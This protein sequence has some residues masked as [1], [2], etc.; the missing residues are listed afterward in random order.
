MKAAVR[1][2][3]ACPVCHGNVMVSDTEV[4][5][6]KCDRRYP[7]VRGVPIMTPDGQHEPAPS[8]P[9]R[10]GYDPW[11]PR[12]TM[13]TLFGV[14]GAEAAILDLGSG[15]LRLDLPGLIRMDVALTDHVDIVADAHHLPFRDDALHMVFSHSVLEHLREPFAAAREM[16][17]VLAP[18]GYVYT[19]TNFVFPYHSFPHHYFNFSPQGM[20]QVFH[21]FRLLHDGV[22]PF[23]LPSFALEALSSAY[24]YTILT[25]SAR[26]RTMFHR[27]RDL[28]FFAGLLVLGSRR[29]WARYDAWFADKAYVVAAGVYWY[30]IKQPNGN[31]TLVPAHVLARHRSDPAMQQRYPQPLDLAAPDN[32]VATT[33]E[34]DV[35]GAF[36]ANAAYVND[37]ALRSGL[38]AK[39]RAAVWAYLRGRPWTPR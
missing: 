25:T 18:G 38:R 31:E 13:A 34:I 12:R 1:R 11:I 39:G 36:V 2:V 32:F 14:L 23:N 27:V 16:Y 26:G 6:A 37:A 22:P 3:I 5:C 33:M 28:A 35:D 19:D 30:G 10:D 15:N 20:A 4:R 9:L 29:V 8:P 21:Q 7:I 17:R 24:V